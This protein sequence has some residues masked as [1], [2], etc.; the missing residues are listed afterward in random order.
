MTMLFIDGFEH[1]GVGGLADGPSAIPTALTQGAYVETPGDGSIG[2]VSWGARTGNNCISNIGNSASP[3]SFRH[4]LN[5]LVSN[6]FVSCGFSVSAFP[7]VVGSRGIV[8]FND[9]SN[10]QLINLTLSPVGILQLYDG[11]GNLLG[12]TQNPVIT[13][14]QV[15]YFLEMNYNQTAGT[16]TLRVNDSTGTGTPALQCT[17]P[18]GTTQIGQVCLLKSVKQQIDSSSTNIDD[19][20]IRD[21]N[22]TYNNG[23]LGDIRI[24][25]I[26]PN[27]DTS[28]TGWTPRYRLNIGAGI[29]NLISSTSEATNP[30]CVSTVSTTSLNVNA[31]DFTIEQFVRFESLPTTSHKAVIFGKWDETNNARSYQL[32]LG[33]PSLNFGDLVFQ[34][35]TDGTA[36]TAVNK[37]T[38]PWSPQLDVWYHVAIVRASGE[39]LLFINGEQLGL[40]ISDTDTY[41]VGTAPASLGGQVEG[42]STGTPKANTGFIGFL[43]EVRFTVGFA[44]Y[45]A[46]FTPTTVPFPR[47]SS[48]DPEFSQVALLA[49]FDIGITDESSFARVLTAHNSAA[50]LAPTDGP[51]IGKYSTVNKLTPQDDT[52]IEAPLVY[53]TSILTLNAQPNAGDTITVGTT[54]GTT[55]AVY[56]FKTSVTTAYDVLIDTSTVL[57][58][59][60]L[61]NAINADPN[62]GPGTKYGTGTTSNADVT[63]TQ[64]PGDQMEV[65]AIVP[66]TAGNS[67]ATSVSLTNGGAWTGSTLAGGA[68]IPGPIEFAVQRPPVNTTLVAASMLVTRALK[69]D[70]GTGIIQPFLVGPLGTVENGSTHAL[71]TSVSDYFDVFE[72]DPDNGGPLSP[73]SIAFGKIGVNRTS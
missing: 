67:V 66:G 61:F 28:V 34:T 52:F 27:A 69:S 16:F 13:A 47:S 15:W 9:F 3:Q 20:T 5:S 36:V 38:Y 7:T 64:L 32:Y 4:V 73:T 39:L 44:R 70:T 2:P 53:A 23:W 45:T 11:S 21:T 35:S 63:A 14:A 30:A 59:F 25:T 72:T 31:G 24:A 60:N 42:S 56:T 43:D 46:P 51:G 29:L 10:N 33:G 26:L 71:S 50:Q 17:V 48:G 6:I 12:G 41:F 49:G 57:T 65:T 8:G 68:G 54:N 22:G 40:P 58:L 1:Y 19:L 18:T 55:P 37:I 62:G